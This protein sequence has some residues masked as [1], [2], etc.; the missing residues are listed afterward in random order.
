MKRISTAALA[1][2]IIVTGIGATP[3]AFAKDKKEEQPKGPQLSKPVFDA[4]NGAKDAITKKDYATAEP[5]VVQAETAAKTDDEKY[6]AQ[7]MRYA[8]V[9]GKADAAAGPNGVLDVKSMIAPLDALIANPK[10]PAAQL[11]SFE[12]T[13]AQI[14]YDQKDW[15]RAVAL[16]KSAKAHGSTEAKLDYYLAQA[17]ASSG[18]SSG[19]EALA[20]SGTVQPEEFYRTATARALAANQRAQAIQWLN[21]WAAAYPTART[22][23]TVLGN[24]AFGRTPIA[25]LDKRTTLDLLRLMRQTKALADAS[26]YEEYAQ[27][28]FDTGLPDE[29]KAVIAEGKATGKIVG[30]GNSVVQ[31]LNQNANAQVASEGSFDGLD[32]KAAASPTGALSAQ[33]GDAYFSKGD[34]AKAVALYRQALTKGVANTDEVNTHLGIALALSG[35]KAGAKAAFGLV[36]TAPRSELASFWLTW[37]DHPVTG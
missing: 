35:D 36:K 5:L 28:A 16:F 9:A 4:V 8:L 33:T 13:R 20:N 17:Q 14:A 21:R 27:N 22:W 11:P 25:K 1:A 2:A 32:K 6:Y 29:S 26:Y 7:L 19:L 18:D 37:I 12:Y 15:A 23:N 24:Y 3:A 34:Y 10:T 30:N 31:T